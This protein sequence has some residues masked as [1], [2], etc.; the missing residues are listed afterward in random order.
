MS[1]PGM[2]ALASVALILGAVTA[3]SSSSSSS[4]SSAAGTGSS[5]S[6]SVIDIG[7]T[8]AFQ[9]G[10]GYPNI[11][12]A[13]QARVDEINAT[14]GINGRKVKLIVCSDNLNVNT[15]VACAQNLV[16]DKI[17]ALV[18]P[19]SAFG[20][21][22][23]PIFNTADITSIGT[24]TGTPSDATHANSFPINVGALGGFAGLPAALKSEGATKIGLLDEG[25]LGPVTTANQAAF[26]SGAKASGFAAS[27]TIGVPGTATDFGPYVAKAIGSG[28]NGVGIYLSNPTSEAKLA[29]TILQQSP[30]MKI[31]IA[32]FGINSQVV[33]ELGST[34]S[35]LLVVGWGQ[36]ASATS[37]PGIAMFNADM[38]K[39]AS[40]APLND[41]DISA[42][43]SVWL[44][45]RV[46]EGL[47]K[48]ITASSVLAAMGKLHGMSMGGIYPPLT[49]T[50]F[51]STCDGATRLFNPD[52]VVGKIVD[53]QVVAVNG[54]FI[55]AF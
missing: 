25:D 15:A 41:L 3:C 43:S 17:V 54:K 55:S 48:N 38:K 39:Y 53:G 27:P 22:I 42:W 14:G 35:H 31:A 16:Q 30:N 33:S 47:G 45:Q 28:V 9:A 36:P 44:F 4:S 24:T 2:A 29:Q 26:D 13:A 11:P 34:A 40:S 8:G 37:L 20:N 52:I 51:C 10:E 46:A 12:Q 23:Y 50:N 19:L 1:R 7:I 18:S 32:G 49:T 21:E 5:A 6:G